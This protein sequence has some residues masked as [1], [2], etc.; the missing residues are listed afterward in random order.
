[1]AEYHTYLTLLGRHGFDMRKVQELAGHSTPTI[2]ARYSQRRLYDLAGA[3]EKLPPLVPTNA[4]ANTDAAAVRCTDTDGDA[5]QQLTSI[6]DAVADAVTRCIQEHWWVAM[7]LSAFVAEI[8]GASSQPAE[9]QPP[10]ACRTRSQ[11]L[12]GVGP[13]GF[14]PRTK[15]L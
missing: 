12:A 1:M 4:G 15:G 5:K 6:S 13:L 14:E 11:R 7:D 3:V 9:T 2:T 10:S 8:S